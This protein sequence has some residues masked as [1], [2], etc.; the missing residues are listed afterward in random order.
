MPLLMALFSPGSSE[1]TSGGSELDSES[2]EMSSG[3]GES[4]RPDLK[5]THSSSASGEAGVQRLLD[6]EE[7]GIEGRDAKAG[8]LAR[9]TAAR[10]RGAT[11]SLQSLGRRPISE[12]TSLDVSHQYDKKE[13]LAGEELLFV[14]L[15]QTV[16]TVIFCV[17]YAANV[18]MTN[19]RDWRLHIDA[20]AFIAA[21]ALAYKLWRGVLAAGPLTDAIKVREIAARPVEPFVAQLPDCSSTSSAAAQA[22]AVASVTG[23]A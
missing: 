9:S 21:G 23:G 5:G 16:I 4:D 13:F 18:L 22:E 10:W 12:V 6:D 17:P 14:V 15:T 8:V 20:I 7:E 1:M 2:S 19:I 3:G 11:S